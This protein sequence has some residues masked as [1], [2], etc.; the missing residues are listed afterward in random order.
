MNSAHKRFLKII[1]KDI[2]YNLEYILFLSML[3][4]I[5]ILII[6]I[7]LNIIHFKAIFW[8]LGMIVCIA[9]VNAIYIYIKDIIIYFKNCWNKSKD[10]ES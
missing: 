6:L 4:G 9:L 10:Y 3:V 1:W 2:V 5:L 8:Y 7:S